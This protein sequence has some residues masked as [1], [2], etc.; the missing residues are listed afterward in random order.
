MLMALLIA[1]IAFLLAGLGGIALGIPVKEFS[2]G[3][4]EILAGVIVGCTGA[5][6]LS[7][8]I[9]IRELKTL[10]R[11]VGSAVVPPIPR[12]PFSLPS[13]LTDP[14]PYEGGLEDNGLLPGLDEIEPEPE[15]PAPSMPSRPWHEETATRG[16]RG[17]TPLPE[18]ELP[19]TPSAIKPRRNLMFTS[20]ARRE[21][22]RE[23][24]LDEAEIADP[25]PAV[26]ASPLP[27]R[28]TPDAPQQPA[29]FEDTWPPPERA[30]I[31]DATSRRAG[32]APAAIAERAMLPVPGEAPVEEPP[33]VTILKSG[34]VDGMAYSLYSDGS[35]EAQM[36]EGMMRFS[37]IDELRA[38][39]DQ[40]GG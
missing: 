2:F 25:K 40:R 31:L 19:A 30:R 17:E 38:H 9:T 5:I 23:E 28:P 39:L 21:R 37:S 18:E 26:T 8:W 20:T 12:P 16:R 24:R 33:Q 13:A 3:N 22:E 36:P 10:A 34:V 14:S 32:R 6:M 15:A 29:N 4:T 27:F 11:R 35:I 7:L 1:G